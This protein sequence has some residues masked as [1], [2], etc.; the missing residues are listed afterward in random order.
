M[1][2]YG[3][4]TIISIEKKSCQSFGIIGYQSFKS[5]ILAAHSCEMIR[6]QDEGIRTMSARE[7]CCEELLRTEGGN[8]F[9]LRAASIFLLRGDS[10]KFDGENEFF[11]EGIF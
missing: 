3:K 8:D 9:W 2:R 6:E 4:V 10:C 7:G 1:D 5:G 11:I